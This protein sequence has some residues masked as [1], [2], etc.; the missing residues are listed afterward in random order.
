MHN[1]VIVEVVRTPSGEGKTGGILS[2]VHPVG[3][4][5]TV[6]R[7]LLSRNDFDPALIDDVIT[8]RVGQGG[9]Q[10]MS[11][12]CTAV[13]AAG[14]PESIPATTVDRQCGSSRQA[15]Q[16]A[17]P[18]IMSRICDVVVAAGGESMSR[19]PMSS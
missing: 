15:A 9:E 8:D 5:A 10:S 16:F 3:L 19:V 6:L 2:G 4:L 18:A 7:E 17:A 1:A 14:Y 11:I 12:G 13:L